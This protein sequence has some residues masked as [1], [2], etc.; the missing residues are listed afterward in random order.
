MQIT[1]SPLTNNLY[2]AKQCFTWNG[3]PRLSVSA[4]GKTHAEALTNCLDNLRNYYHVTD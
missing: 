3:K 4:T 2:V 1:K